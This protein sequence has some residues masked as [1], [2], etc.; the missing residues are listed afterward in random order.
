MVNKELE[1]KVEEKTKE[2]KL[3]YE[4]ISQQQILL[5]QENK[6]LKS[7]LHHKTSSFKIIG[8][9]KSLQQLL[10]MVDRIAPTNATVL[11]QGESGTG[12][13]LIAKRLHEMSQRKEGPYIMINCSALHENLLKSELFGHEK[14]AFTGAHMLK[15]GLVETAHLGT[16]FMDEI[17]EMGSGIQ[18]KLLRF[19][20][21]GEFYRV[22]GKQALKVNVRVISATNK[23]LEKEVKEGRFREDLFYRLNTIT[24]RVP[25]LRKRIEDIDLLLQHFL[26]S[27]GWGGSHVKTIH[28]NAL[29][30]L[31]QYHWPGNIRELQNVM[32]RLKILCD[33]NEITADDV[34]NHIRFP[35][36]KRTEEPEEFSSVIAL[37]ELEKVH[38]LKAL[39]HFQG[40]KTQTARAL[41]ITIKT[42]YNK[43]S[44]YENVTTH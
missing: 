3:A 13:E 18:A 40:N 14:G 5:Q 25:P 9:S 7:Y 20:Q 6:S 17:A 16:L 19:L 22:G 32:E 10:H 1:K 34:K 30:L 15:Q 38:I 11:L 27:D 35:S 36:N 44:R 41:G 29:E 31:K 21:E 24:L 2:L 28:S 4:K 43:L 8:S 26:T 33:G 39:S 23:D 12:K 37:G 42:L